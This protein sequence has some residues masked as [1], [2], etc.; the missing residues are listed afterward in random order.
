VYQNFEL[1]IQNFRR[2]E[3]NNPQNAVNVQYIFKKTLNINLFI[4]VNHIVVQYNIDHVNYI[5]KKVYQ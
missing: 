1:G 2:N 5:K 4:F 3:I